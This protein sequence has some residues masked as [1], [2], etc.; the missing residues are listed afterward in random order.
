M[1]RLVIMTRLYKEVASTNLSIKD[2]TY[3]A[4]STMDSTYLN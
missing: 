1:A 2:D 3:I 4:L